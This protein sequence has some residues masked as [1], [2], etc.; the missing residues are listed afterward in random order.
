[1][2][3]RR[4]AIL[5]AIQAA[6][7][8]TAG[9]SGRVFR[10]RVEARDRDQMPCVT[11][12]ADSNDPQLIGEGATRND[13]VFKLEYEARAAD[14]DAALDPSVCDA[15]ARLYAD[16]TFGGLAAG[17]FEMPA[18]WEWDEADGSALRLTVKYRVVFATR[19]ADLTAAP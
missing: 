6:L 14:P 16:Y 3:S 17:L 7:L 1:M 9:L 11:I 2:S 10:S 19:E 13:F 12:L 4:L 5:D 15:H 18:Q 8:P